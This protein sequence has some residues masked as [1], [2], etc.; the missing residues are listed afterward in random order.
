LGERSVPI[1]EGDPGCR[2]RPSFSLQTKIASLKAE[3][4]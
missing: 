3:K 2:A 1:V 4:S